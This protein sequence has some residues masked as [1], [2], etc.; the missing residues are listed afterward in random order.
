MN[1][2]CQ[3]MK[4]CEDIKLLKCGSIINWSSDRG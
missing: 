4:I 2:I 3:A 1:L